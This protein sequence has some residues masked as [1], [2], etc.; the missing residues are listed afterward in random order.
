LVTHA[1][2]ELLPVDSKLDIKIHVEPSKDGYLQ[3]LSLQ[4]IKKLKKQKEPFLITWINKISGV[5]V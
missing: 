2:R 5:R 3:L 4:F 1:G